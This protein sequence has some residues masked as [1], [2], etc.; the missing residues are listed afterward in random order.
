MRSISFCKYSIQAFMTSSE[1]AF[2][3]VDLDEREKTLKENFGK[4]RLIY[5]LGPTILKYHFLFKTGVMVHN[6]RF[7]SKTFIREYKYSS[8]TNNAKVL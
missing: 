4:K 5:F 3:T 1:S 2:K 6:S 7:F 8:S